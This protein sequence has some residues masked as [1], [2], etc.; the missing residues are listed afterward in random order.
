MIDPR[1]TDQNWLRHRH[2]ER[3]GV[4]LHY[5]VADSALGGQPRGTVVLVHGFPHFWFTW[6]RMIPV[7]VEA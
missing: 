7:L 1:I 5:V 2:V 4:R 3:D 6:H